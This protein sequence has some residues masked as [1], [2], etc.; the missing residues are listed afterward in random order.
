MSRYPC[1][2]AGK[3][4]PLPHPLHGA[5]YATPPKEYARY[6]TDGLPFGVAAQQPSDKGWR[7]LYDW[8]IDAPADIADADLLTVS[9]ATQDVLLGF[10]GGPACKTVVY[11]F[12]KNSVWDLLK[13]QVDISA[14]VDA[15]DVRDILLALLQANQDYPGARFRADPDD[16]TR[17]LVYCLPSC[18]VGYT[19]TGGGIKTQTDR[20]I[21]YRDQFVQGGRAPRMQAFQIVFGAGGSPDVAFTGQQAYRNV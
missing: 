12:D 4:G 11:E 21:Y 15:E 16:V 18:D 2:Y 13:E 7:Y 19:L 17:I 10:A 8:E 1:D 6:S 3:A 20:E 9:V 14:A 5:R